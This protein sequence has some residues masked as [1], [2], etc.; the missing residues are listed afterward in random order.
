MMTEVFRLKENVEQ[1][2]AQILESHITVLCERN[3]VGCAE[4]AI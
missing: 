3:I 4:N 2:V 1:M